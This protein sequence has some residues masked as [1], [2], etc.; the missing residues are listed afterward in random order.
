MVRGNRGYG[1]NGLT[2]ATKQR[3]QSNGRDFCIPSRV[4][5]ALYALYQP[6]D[7]EVDHQADWQVCE[8]QIGQN[9]CLMDRKDLR[10]RFHFNHYGVVDEQVQAVMAIER[11]ALVGEWNPSFGDEREFPRSQFLLQTGGVRGFEETRPQ[12]AVDLDRRCDD[13]ACDM[14]EGWLRQHADGSQQDGH[15][16]DLTGLFA[17]AITEVAKGAYWTRTGVRR[18]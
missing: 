8:P 7:I 18:N 16:V 5:H 10:D 14:V 2:G 1:E 13:V 12:L 15:L 3:R 6:V 11:D 9:L 4:D 17:Q